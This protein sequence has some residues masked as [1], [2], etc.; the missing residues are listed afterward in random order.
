MKALVVCASLLA[1]SGTA[2]AAESFGFAVNGHRVTVT[3]HKH[4]HG[5]SCLEVSVPGMTIGRKGVARHDEVATAE[6]VETPAPAAKA[7]TPE[8]VAPIATI[9]APPAVTPPPSG[10]EPPTTP[11]TPAPATAK[12]ETVVIGTTIIGTTAPVSTPKTE[13]AE[14]GDAIAPTTPLPAAPS[15]AAPIPAARTP[16]RKVASIAPVD[17]S[18]EQ[19]TA[20]A[21]PTSPIGVWRTEKKEGKVHIVACGDRLCG[22]AFDDKTKADGA[23]V[24]ID[25]KHVGGRKWSGRI[26]DSRTGGTYDSTIAL[27]GAATLR[28]QGCAFGGFFCGGQTWTRL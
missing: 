22:Y 23:K 18:G 24:L 3:I 4:C 19:A 13:A 9:I 25:M 15:A 5:L 7:A 6:P 11:A 20:P 12:S 16:E 21:D 2:R 27:N 10:E 14:I 1:A 28:V 17:A 26:H 8:P